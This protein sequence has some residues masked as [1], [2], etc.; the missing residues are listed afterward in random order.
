MEKRLGDRDRALK[1]L[2]DKLT[3]LVEGE[4]GVGGIADDCGKLVRDFADKHPDKVERTL[5][6]IKQ[7]EGKRLMYKRPA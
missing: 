6:L 3:P 4:N 5:A 2:R 1:Y 7:T